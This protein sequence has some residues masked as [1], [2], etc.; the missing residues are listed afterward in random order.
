MSNNNN[1]NNHNGQ[2]M[3]TMNGIEDMANNP[4]VSQAKVLQQLETLCNDYAR[5]VHQN[6]V[7]Q[8]QIE[9]QTHALNGGA[10]GLHTISAILHAVANAQ[11]EA[12]QMHLENSPAQAHYHIKCKVS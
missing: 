12:R 6:S 9:A 5:A 8:T 1:N 11:H 3:Y 7:L 4:N 2:A 10:T